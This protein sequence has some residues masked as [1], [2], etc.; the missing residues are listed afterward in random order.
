[1]GEL[2]ANVLPLAAGA[3]ISPTL[4]GLQ[5]LTL[6]SPVQPLRRS[7][8]VAAGAGAVL[9]GYSLFASLAAV[10]TNENASSPSEVGAI[11][12]L[13][14]AVALLGLGLRNLRRPQRPKKP[15]PDGGEARL[16]RSFALGALMMATNIT[17]L[18]LYFPAMHDIGISDVDTGGQL[19]AFALLYGITMTVAVGPPLATA[20]LG[21]RGRRAV[22]ALGGF[23]DVHHR[24]IS[25]GVPLVFAAVLAVEAIPELV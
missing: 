6:S 2:L 17:T 18:A 13:A 5:L 14:I 15:P 23:M 10:G 19:V 7:W 21:E 16:G 3:A 9:L 8:A 11:L 1:L 25:V 4:L 22:H 20:L 12:K 24:A